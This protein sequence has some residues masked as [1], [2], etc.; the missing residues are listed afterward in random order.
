MTGKELA[1]YSDM[2]A[3]IGAAVKRKLTH[4]N[5]PAAALRAELEKQGFAPWIVQ[6][7]PATHEAL[8]MRAD[9][10]H[11]T[12]EKAGIAARTVRDFARDYSAAFA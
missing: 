8:T 3:A 11:D 5:V 2:L 12:L 4:T 7:I 10:Y 1:N 9:M 6:D